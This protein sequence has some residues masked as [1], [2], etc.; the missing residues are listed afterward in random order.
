MER[1]L[2]LLRK[3][4]HALENLKNGRLLDSLSDGNLVL[5]LKLQH[6]LLD[7]EL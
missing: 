5:V 4:K 1:L 6:H 2:L 7:L 3:L